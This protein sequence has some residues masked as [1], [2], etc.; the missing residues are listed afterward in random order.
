MLSSCNPLGDKYKKKAYFDKLVKQ[1]SKM[2][3]IFKAS[4]ANFSD[5]DHK[6]LVA[7]LWKNVQRNTKVYDIG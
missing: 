5:K 7:C 1:L 3:Y 4:V 6:S 2:Y